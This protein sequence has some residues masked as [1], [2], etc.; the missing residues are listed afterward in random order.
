V[1]YRFSQEAI[2][3]AQ[4]FD[5]K[6]AI[7]WLRANAAKYNIDPDRIGVW[8]ASA[9]AHLAAMLGTSGGAEALEGSLGAFTNASSRVQCVVDCFGPSDFTSLSRNT[10]SI[11]FGAAGS[12]ESRLI[13]GTV[14]ENPEAARSASP[15]TY[16]SS[17][18]PPF[19][20]AHGTKD[21]TVPFSQS[22]RMNK[23]LL[24]AGATTSPVF[25]HMIGAGHGFHSGELNRR[26]A[27]FFDLHLCGR[28]AEI[29][30]DP[31]EE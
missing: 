1:E 30:A 29:S 11:R 24:D 27:Q 22:E 31:I 4:I 9:G 6:A 10:N 16:A 3:P 12:P 23:A 13:G 17:D 19:L 21:N 18:D 7:R 20:I 28:P 2:W 5:C 25:I 14:S 8:G 26:V 15:A